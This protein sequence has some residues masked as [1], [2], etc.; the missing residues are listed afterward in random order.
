MPDEVNRA[1]SYRSSTRGRQRAATSSAIAEAAGALFVEFGYAATTI[2][3]IASRADVSP[4]TVYVIFGT[5]RDVLRSVVEAAATGGRES[6][7]DDAWLEQV[8]VEPDQR[9]RLAL[10]AEATRDV[11]RRVAPIDEVVRS[12]A[13]ADPEIAELQREHDERRLRDTRV[14]AKLLA[15]VGPLRVP[16]DDAA[17]L[18]WALSRSTDL[19]RALTVDRGWS[20]D[21]AFDAL[22]DVLARVLLPDEHGSEH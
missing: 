10:M 20:D 16:V 9:R 14:L 8:R 17:E 6:V 7:L 5:K 15:D 19:Y 18:M 21:R 13:T 22:N 1:R 12:V 11:L 3:K 2:T 4:E